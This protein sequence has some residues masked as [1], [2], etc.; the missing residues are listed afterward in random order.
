MRHRITLT[1]SF[2]ILLAIGA[3]ADAKQKYVL[4]NLVSDEPGA[5]I[6]DTNLVNP[7]GI[8]IN[9]AAGAFWVSNNGTGTSTLYLGDVNGSAFQQVPLVVAIPD[10]VPTGVVF[11]STTDFLITNGTDTSPA[12]FIFVSEAGT[13]SAWNTNVPLNSPA[14][15]GATVTGA[16]FKAVTIGSNATGNFLY[17][18]DFHN[19]QIDVFDA[20]FNLVTLT[21]SFTDPA[22]P[23][24]YAPFNIQNIN[25]SLYVTYALADAASE[26]EVAGKKLGFVS[27][28]DTDGNLV[29]HLIE[30][31]KLN[32]PWGLA[33]APA[34]FGPL[35]NALLV[36]N[37][38]NGQINGYDPSTGAFIGKL[39]TK[40]GKKALEGL[41]AISFGNGVSAGDLNTLYF[42]AGPE[43]ETHGRFGSIR[44]PQP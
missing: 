30:H 1:I 8:A 6:Q 3:F 16:I 24:E 11:N 10:A 39:K 28:Y 40:P 41:W 44:F 4:T 17:A 31:G 35:S 34:D 9:P 23:P 33:L 12:L 36:G 14:I 21:G 5:L 13:V 26:D 29:K 38:G 42:T 25:G 27:V 22:I 43:D 15:V 19:H 37:F 32:A 2:F 18:A 7:W 20:G